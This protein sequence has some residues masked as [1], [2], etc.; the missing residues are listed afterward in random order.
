DT[1]YETLVYSLVY[2]CKKLIQLWL[3]FAPV[4]DRSAKFLGVSLEKINWLSVV[5][6]VVAI[7]LSFG[8]TWMLDTLGLP[9]Q[10]QSVLFIVLLQSLTKRLTDSPLSTCGDIVL[11]WKVPLMLM[12]GL[13]TFFSCC[14]VIFFNTRYR[15]LEAEE[16]AVYG[17]KPR[18]A[19][20]GDFRQFKVPL[21]NHVPKRAILS[22]PFT[23]LCYEV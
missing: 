2:L 14:F 19:S 1:D 10:I 8:S 21:I 12:A 17:T 9:R 18:A 16:Q 4:A 20:T 23:C 13:C 5:Y 6:M 7:P 22:I 3:T 15:R 11:S